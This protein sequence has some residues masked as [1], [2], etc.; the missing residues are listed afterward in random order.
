MASNPSPLDRCEM[1]RTE[2]AGSLILVKG[3]VKSNPE[4]HYIVVSS[5]K[6]AWNGPGDV[7]DLDLEKLR[8]HY[9]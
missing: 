3:L 4:R 7:F 2:L 5:W 9:R 8:R 1:P 6:T